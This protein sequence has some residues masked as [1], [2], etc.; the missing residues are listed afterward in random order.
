MSGLGSCCPSPQ[1]HPPLEPGQ[2]SRGVSGQARGGPLPLH[3][4]L[5]ARSWVDHVGR[6]NYCPPFSTPG[7]GGDRLWLL[8]LISFAVGGGGS[9][10]L[11][12]FKFLLFLELPLRGRTE[13]KPSW[14]LGLSACWHVPA[15]PS[16]LGVL[17]FQ[18][19]VR[20]AWSVAGLLT[21][22]FLLAN[23]RLTWRQ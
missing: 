14:R 12:N 6:P 22:T 16:R 7:A 1:D 3:T 11:S 10:P 19:C 9:C 20:G 13:G 2:L 18:A 21:P 8:P 4:C 5:F 15:S 17:E 23:I